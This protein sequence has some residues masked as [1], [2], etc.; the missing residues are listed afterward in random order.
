MLK[1]TMSLYMLIANKIFAA[2]KV[3]NIKS[4]D[5]LIKKC[6]KL[7]KTEKLFKSQKSAKLGKKLL[8]SRNLPNFNVKK[9]K[10]SFLTLNTRT[11]FNRL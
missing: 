4:G 11:T 6:G 5:E 2:D 9:N 3:G 8:K 1:T 10:P 7:S